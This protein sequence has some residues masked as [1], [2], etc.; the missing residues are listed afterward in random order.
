MSYSTDVHSV[1]IF[2]EILEYSGFNI[3]F[4]VTP[5]KNQLFSKA[6]DGILSHLMA[7]IP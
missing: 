3:T 4:Y 7:L 1:K 5:R 2:N 6:I